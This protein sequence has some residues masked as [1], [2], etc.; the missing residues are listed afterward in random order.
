MRPIGIVGTF[1]GLFTH[2]HGRKMEHAK[3]RA[4]TCEVSEPM[5]RAT[6]RCVYRLV[7]RDRGPP[8]KMEL[9]DI[10][11]TLGHEEVVGQRACKIEVSRKHKR[12]VTK[13]TEREEGM[14]D[15]H[16]LAIDSTCHGTR[17]ANHA[18]GAGWKSAVHRGYRET[19]DR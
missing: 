2:L 9:S 4:A 17:C 13:L 15:V 5:E 1:G 10:R 11:P 7:P 6:T 18:S 8:H 12:K 14:E 19:C 16:Q 3:P